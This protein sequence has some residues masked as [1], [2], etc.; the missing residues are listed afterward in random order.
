MNGTGFAPLRESDDPASQK[1]FNQVNQGSDP[2]AAVHSLY[3]HLQQMHRYIDIH[4]HHPAAA[5]TGDL[6]VVNL[7]DDFA[8]TTHGYPC[9]AGLHPWYLQNHETAFRGL[10]AI[11]TLPNVLAV[12]EC[13]LD[14][15]CNTGMQL[16]HAVF[17]KQVVLAGKVGKPLIIHCVRAFD[18]LTHLLRDAN[19]IVP[20]IIHGFNKN[21][22]VADLLLAQGC[23]LS[24]G[25][26]I[27]N[28]N[29]PAAQALA[30]IPANRFFLETDDAPV[31]ISEVYNM[32]AAIRKTS[33]EDIILQVQ[34][35]FKT[36]FRP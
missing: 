20:L 5:P 30:T 4:T 8:R 31:T 22:R 15:R 17:L 24:F 12:G 23:C 2:I 25:A 18:A 33:A 1:S 35:N 6:A 32:A 16:Q 19:P 3:L 7:Y 9:S 29:S 11:A 26:A 36:A 27:A 34:N 28:P 21:S 10:E 13:G 14:A